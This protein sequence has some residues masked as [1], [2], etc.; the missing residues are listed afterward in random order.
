V[1]RRRGFGRA[2][3][4]VREHVLID[5]VCGG[6]EVVYVA[7]TK[8]AR[9]GGGCN[10]GFG[11]DGACSGAHTVKKTKRRFWSVEGENEDGRERGK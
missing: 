1:E 10:D 11:G 7:V 2:H 8:G 9:Y 3:I 5:R 4:H 6:P